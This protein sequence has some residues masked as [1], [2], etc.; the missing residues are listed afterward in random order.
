MNLSIMMMI[1]YR[2]S[3]TFQERNRKLS[4]KRWGN[5]TT[6]LQL[7][8]WINFFCCCVDN[9]TVCVWFFLS[10]WWLQIDEKINNFFRI[11]ND[12]DDDE[13]SIINKKKLDVNSIRFNTWLSRTQWKKKFFFILKKT[14][15]KS[16]QVRMKNFWSSIHETRIQT[17]SAFL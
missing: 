14:K 3:E 4:Q 6:F 12:D 8:F 9:H 10:H 7:F 5:Q 16:H 2:G 11:D 15:R 1:N 17:F 13:H